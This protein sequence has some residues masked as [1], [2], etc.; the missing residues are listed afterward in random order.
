[1][2]FARI[3]NST[4]V[5]IIDLGDRTP[6]DCFHADFADQF[7]A[8]GADVEVGWHIEGGEFSPP[9]MPQTNLVQLKS[10]LKNEVD[11]AAET[12]R[13]KYITP[14]DGQA[15]TYQQKVTEA[16]ALKATSNPQV[17]YYPLLSSE[18]GITAET[19]SD[20]ADIV[21]AAFAMWQQ[22]GA[23]IEGIRL[24]A[25]IDIDA[26]ADEATAHAI[27]DAIEWPQPAL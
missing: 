5:E 19:L 12:E 15:M 11:A 7:V 17:S 10:W 13:L 20:V 4:V 2:R 26:A 22:I 3:D 18:V 21:L 1:M 23:A 16:Q 9:V 24:G 14:G 25:K 6:S 27:V 8:V